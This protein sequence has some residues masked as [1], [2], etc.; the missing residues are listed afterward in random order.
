M[1]AM[2]GERVGARVGFRTRVDGASGRQTVVLVVTTGLL[3][4]RLQQV[5][6]ILIASNA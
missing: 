3:L 2:L 5:R 4:R 1:A 6:R